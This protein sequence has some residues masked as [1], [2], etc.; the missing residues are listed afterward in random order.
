MQARCRPFHA[1]L[2]KAN[3]SHP[4]FRNLDETPT[5][6]TLIVGLRV[7]NASGCSREA[8]FDN[9]WSINISEPPGKP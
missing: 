8:L 6:A 4:Y 1:K 5:P 9:L 3:Y 7:P 2:R